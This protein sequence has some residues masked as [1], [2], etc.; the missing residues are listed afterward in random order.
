MK[1]HEIS[2]SKLVRRLPLSEKRILQVTE[3]V[4][5]GEKIARSEISI[6]VVGDKR[7]AD[8]AEKYARRRYRTDVFAFDL[9]DDA[10]TLTGQIILNSELAR[11]Q[12]GKLKTDAGSELALYLVHGLLHLAG[13]DDHS[14]TEAEK[15]YLLS[16]KY[17]IK[18]GF[19]RI[20]PVPVFL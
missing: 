13:Y 1:R 10:R 5:K 2:I 8:F 11:D 16:K 7:M 3:L 14:K 18:S 17:L 19:K 20:P 6:A 9:S 12:A 15:M 4:L